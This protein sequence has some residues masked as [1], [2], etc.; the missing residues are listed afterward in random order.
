MSTS[1]L[2][3]RIKPT[4]SQLESIH[5]C[6]E[7][8]LE[9]VTNMQRDISLRSGIID[10][11]HSFSTSY[12]VDHAKFPEMLKAILVRILELDIEVDDIPG[13]FDTHELIPTHTWDTFFT[14]VEENGAPVDKVISSLTKSIMEIISNDIM[15]LSDE[16]TK[17]CNR[18]IDMRDAAVNALD[19]LIK[20]NDG[21]PGEMRSM[22]TRVGWSSSLR[23]NTLKLK[24]IVYTCNAVLR[25][26][27][28]K[29]SFSDSVLG[30]LISQSPIGPTPVMTVGMLKIYSDLTTGSD[31]DN[32]D[33]F[34]ETVTVEGITAT[35]DNTVNIGRHDLNV[36]KFL[37]STITD[38]TQV[39]LHRPN[40]NIFVSDAVLI[41]LR[42]SLIEL[43]IT[44]APGT[45]INTLTRRYV[46]EIEKCYAV[47]E[48]AMSTGI[49]D[50][51]N[52]ALGIIFSSLTVSLFC[53]HNVA[54]M[55]GNVVDTCT[56]DNNV[57]G[58]VNTK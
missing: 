51:V 48:D 27:S 20:S 44:E 21:Y 35:A 58:P 10:E 49:G 14:G 28:S 54:V 30:D 50:A 6:F 24:D 41:A 38:V 17:Y 18:S 57:T 9:E 29:L 8:M 11:L 39:F 25:E 1:D 13:L 55:T 53:S 42:D 12:K 3:E 15:C 33:E 34:S 45:N 36:N 52:V 5:V 46:D 47:E 19:I 40:V 32:D 37:Q 26:E 23:D 4:P 31:S 43:P 2:I 56:F 22:L 16:V 7:P